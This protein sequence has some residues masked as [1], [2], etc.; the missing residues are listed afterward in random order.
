VKK[1]N[2]ISG[3]SLLI[4]ICLIFCGSVGL[5]GGDVEAGELRKVEKLTEIEIL[6]LKGAREVAREA[7]DKL[8]ELQDRIARDHKMNS[9]YYMEWSSWYEINGDFILLYYTNHM[10]GSNFILR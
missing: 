4:A 10:G 3:V 8:R 9:V 6:Q 5:K 2:Q 7:N 1:A